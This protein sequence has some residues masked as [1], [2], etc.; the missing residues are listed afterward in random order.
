MRTKRSVSGEGRCYTLRWR[1]PRLEELL[2]LRSE[3]VPRACSPLRAFLAQAK[4]KSVGRAWRQ[5]LWPMR[6]HDEGTAAL[7]DGVHRIDGGVA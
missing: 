3:L 4:H 5:V 6:H 7:R 2:Y 1:T